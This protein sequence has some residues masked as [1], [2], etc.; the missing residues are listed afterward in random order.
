MDDLPSESNM[1]STGLK[2]FFKIMELWDASIDDIEILLGGLSRSSIYN[3]KNTPPSKLNRDQLCRI[4][5]IIGIYKG[6]NILYPDPKIS[7]EWVHRPN[8]YFGGRTAF[9]HMLGGN[10]TDLADVRR[11]IDA[12]CEGMT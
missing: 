1:A 11:R 6:L 8:R 4:S 7:D 3:W 2:V 5:Y 12:A 9:Q 10:I